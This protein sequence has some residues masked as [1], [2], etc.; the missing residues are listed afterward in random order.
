MRRLLRRSKGRAGWWVLGFEILL[1][2]L[3]SIHLQVREL[4]RWTY[5]S[6]D[7]ALVQL[8]LLL[9]R[10]R[11]LR[12]SSPFNDPDFNTSLAVAVLVT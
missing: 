9:L 1:R 8:K 12:P 3:R 6:A 11:C 5:F 10:E 4:L 7:V 2:S